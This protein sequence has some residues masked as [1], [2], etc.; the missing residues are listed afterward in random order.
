MA[1]IG[2][3]NPDVIIN[4]KKLV[5][6]AN[7]VEVTDGLGEAKVEALSGGAGVTVTAHTEDV[8]TKV[9]KF[10]GVLFPNVNQGGLDVREEVRS[11]KAA[12][13]ASNSISVSQDDVHYSFRNMTLIT[14]PT[15][16]LDSAPEVEIEFHG[17]PAI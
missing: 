17:D 5:F 3:Y 13:L 6:K 8:S 12:P 15:A 4:N 14:D 16:K 9:G 2:L 10:K 7:S 11:W 1:V